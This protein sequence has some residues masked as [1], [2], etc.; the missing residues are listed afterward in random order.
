MM[1][2]MMMILMLMMMMMKLFFAGA[3]HAGQYL[4]KQI[5][6]TLKRPYSQ[7]NLKGAL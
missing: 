1:M 3:T 2:M 6:V 5:H 7:N 4:S